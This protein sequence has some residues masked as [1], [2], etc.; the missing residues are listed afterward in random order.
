[1]QRGGSPAPRFPW[2]A[3]AA[4][5]RPGQ[6]RPPCSRIPDPPGSSAAAAPAPARPGGVCVGRGRAAGA[7]GPGPPHGRASSW[8]A[9]AVAPPF[10]VGRRAARTE[11]PPRP[12]VSEHRTGPDRGL[13]PGAVASIA[14]PPLTLPWP[15]REGR[16]SAAP[17]RGSPPPA[18]PAQHAAEGKD[19]AAAAH[20]PTHPPTGARG[21]RRAPGVEAGGG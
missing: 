15:R 14:L 1:M 6:T 13:R 12:R 11:G 20:P 16:E 4:G 17:R 8:R 18:L 3:H 21:P 10:S 9:A 7:G 5:L 2:G 19:P